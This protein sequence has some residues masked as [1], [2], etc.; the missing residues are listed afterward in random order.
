MDDIAG[1]ALEKPTG[2]STVGNSG[3]NPEH[4]PPPL[5]TPSAEGDRLNV[6]AA[7]ILTWICTFCRWAN[8]NNNGPCRKCGGQTEMKMVNDRWKEVTIKQPVRRAERTAS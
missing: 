7:M 8:D 4:R 2:E 3:S 5:L 1:G 6:G